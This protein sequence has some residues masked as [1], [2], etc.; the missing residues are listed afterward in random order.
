MG[1]SRVL[2]LSYCTQCDPQSIQ[3]PTTKKGRGTHQDLQWDLEWNYII[4]KERERK[5]IECIPVVFWI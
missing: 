2:P 5:G 1:R 4:S 3:G